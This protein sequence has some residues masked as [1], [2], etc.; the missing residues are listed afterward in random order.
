M[1]HFPFNIVD[2][3]H[4]LS[5]TAPSWDGSCGFEHHAIW[6]YETCTTQVK[7]RV[8]H[9]TMHAGIGTHMDAPAH[10]IP[11]GKTIDELSLESL[12]SPCIVIDISQHA[13]EAYQCAPSDIQTFER[14]YGKIP[15]HAFVIIRTGWDAYWTQPKKYRNNLR[16]PTIAL[17]TAKLLLEREIAGLG[18]DTLSPDNE[19][20]GYQVHQIILGAGKYLVENVSSSS[21]LPPVGSFS[22]ALPMMI[23]DGTEAPIRL[24]ALLPKDHHAK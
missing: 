20:N 11:G 7:F 3:T 17:D 5:P 8:Q 12:I 21:K 16:F 1:I 13:H 15:K 2:L 19:S 4:P 18:I 24:I 6:D 9:I 22:M 14:K 23:Q 10:C